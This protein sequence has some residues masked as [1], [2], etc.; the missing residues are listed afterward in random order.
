MLKEL[1]VNGAILTVEDVGMGHAI[2]FLHAG[3]ADRRMWDPPFE[4]LSASFRVIRWDARGFG[5]TPHVPGPFSYAAD[6]LAVMDGLGV[7]T[8]T[9]IG[10]SMGGSTAIRVAL[11]EPDRVARLVLVGSGLHGFER[12][13]LLPPI[14]SEMQ[15]AVEA[16]DWDRFLG[17]EEK[18]WIIG[19]NR[20]ESQVEPTF[21]ALCRDMQRKALQP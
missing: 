4:W 7:Q 18:F 11:T 19:M 9:L 21:L 13:D 15:A 1:P 14:V 20:D 6:V 16:Q 17:L 5:D 2:I 10:C 12:P 3:V 8:A